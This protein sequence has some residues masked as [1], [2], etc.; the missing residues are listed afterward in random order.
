VNGVDDRVAGQS[1]ELGSEPPGEPSADAAQQ[2]DADTLRNLMRLALGGAFEGS[3]ELVRRLEHWQAQAG[4]A[5]RPGATPLTDESDLA[6]LRFALVGLMFEAPDVVERGA[7]NLGS[8]TRASTGFLSRVVAP[9]AASRAARPIVRRYDAFVDDRLS[10]LERWIAAG[11]A[12]E[13]SSRSM[14]RDLTDEEV[15]TVIEYLADKPEVRELIQEQ[16]L[17]MADDAVGEL[18]GQTASADRLIER[19]VSSSLRRQPADV[20]PAPPPSMPNRARSSGREK[21]SG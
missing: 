16:S 8:A 10:T 18:R 9:L 15:N 1:T 20:E 4:E 17:S 6:R 3:A 2:L 5:G 7:R 11:R 19:I 12:E 13:Q 14:V 21:K